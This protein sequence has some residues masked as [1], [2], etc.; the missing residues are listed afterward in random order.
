PGRPGPAFSFTVVLLTVVLFTT[1]SFTTVTFCGS[2]MRVVGA[3]PAV[4]VAAGGGKGGAFLTWSLACAAW[5]FDGGGACGAVAA[6][7]PEGGV[8]PPPI[9]RCLALSRSGASWPL[10]TP[11]GSL[12]TGSSGCLPAAFCWPAAAAPWPAPGVP[13]CARRAWKASHWAAV[14]M[15]IARHSGGSWPAAAAGVAVAGVAEAAGA[16]GAAG[17]AT[18]APLVLAPVVAA[19]VACGAGAAGAAGWAAAGV[20]AAAGAAG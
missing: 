8:R 18:G 2:W 13:R 19:G 17:V 4:G 20:A 6:G 3:V 1:V 10:V 14:E 9:W 7:L 15:P 5:S 12:V 11:G 16:A